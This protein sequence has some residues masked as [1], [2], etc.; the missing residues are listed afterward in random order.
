MSVIINWTENWKVVNM[1]KIEL[2]ET[3][4]KK[5]DMLNAQLKA[6]KPG[7]QSFSS[8]AYPH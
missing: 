2:L 6:I 8:P 3:L 1:D 7:G 5:V 4:Y